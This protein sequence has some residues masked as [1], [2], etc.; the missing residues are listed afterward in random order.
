MKHFD[1]LFAK[2]IKLLLEEK[3][4][5]PP[6]AR[7]VI[8]WKNTGGRWD[9]ILAGLTQESRLSYDDIVSKSSASGTQAL[10]LMAKLGV[11]K[12]AKS[13]KGWKEPTKS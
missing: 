5:K 8:V 4:Q 7:D 13:K 1:A 12:E 3:K 10:S 11:T 9:P 2:A 6:T